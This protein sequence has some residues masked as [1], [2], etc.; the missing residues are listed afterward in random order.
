MMLKKDETI[1][2]LPVPRRWPMA[3]IIPT[4]AKYTKNW[5]N[6]KRQ[7]QNLMKPENAYN[8]KFLE[9]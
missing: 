2:S 3:D 8:L 5:L 4:P 7:P 6:E 9:Y 1:W